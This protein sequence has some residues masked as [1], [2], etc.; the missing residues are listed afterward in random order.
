MKHAIC[1]YLELTLFIVAGWISFLIE[2]ILFKTGL[3]LI[4]D[5]DKFQ[6]NESV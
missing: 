2:V 3:F 1:K 4:K 6:S 5:C